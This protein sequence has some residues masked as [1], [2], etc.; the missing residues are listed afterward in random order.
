MWKLFM[1]SGFEQTATILSYLMGKYLLGQN[2]KS[3]FSNNFH[4]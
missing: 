1:L 2:L 4:L 3:D